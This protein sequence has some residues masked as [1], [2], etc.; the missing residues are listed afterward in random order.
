MTTKRDRF[1]EQIWND[2]RSAGLKAG[3]VAHTSTM[4]ITEAD[5]IGR[6]VAGARRYVE[7]EGPCG[8]AW[9]IVKPGNCGFAN[10][11]KA[12][13]H[14]RPE[15]YAGGV[16]IWISDFNQ[17]MERKE[18]CAS[19]MATVLKDALVSIHPNI[20]IYSDSRMD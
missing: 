16:N 1:Y 5:F 18:A 3:E 20:R 6:P 14:A 15:S 13:G 10:W 11:L 19:A 7:P 9:I 2:A 8:C 4:I 17:S 12:N